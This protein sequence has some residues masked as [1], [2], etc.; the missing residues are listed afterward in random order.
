MKFIIHRFSWDVVLGKGLLAFN[1]TLPHTGK[2]TALPIIVLGI[3][4]SNASMHLCKY[5]VLQGTFCSI[6]V[7]SYFLPSNSRDSKR[8]MQANK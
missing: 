5:R 4:L 8:C 1:F 6:S 2:L 7:L 3:L